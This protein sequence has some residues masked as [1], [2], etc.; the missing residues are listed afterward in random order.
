VLIDSAMAICGV[1]GPFSPASSL[2]TPYQPFWH[3]RSKL[4]GFTVA[5]TGY[6][7]GWPSGGMQR[8]S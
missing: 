6:V 5:V 2:G 7:S 1:N 8:L 4:T 3:C